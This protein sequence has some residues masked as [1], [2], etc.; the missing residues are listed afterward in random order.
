MGVVGE[1]EPGLSIARGKS[2][3]EVSMGCDED[4][5]GR[6]SMYGKRRGPAVLLYTEFANPQKHNTVGTERIAYVDYIMVFVCILSGFDP[7]KLR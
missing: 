1:R 7:T 4:G 3:P 5:G 6:K 2:V